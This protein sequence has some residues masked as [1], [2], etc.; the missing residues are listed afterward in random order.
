MECFQNDPNINGIVIV[1]LKGYE[2]YVQALAEQFKITKFLGVTLGGSCGQESI[3]NGLTLLSHF[4]KP[5]DIVL[6]HDG[7]RPLVSS[8]VIDDCIATTEKQGNACAAT[9]CNEAMLE[10]LDGLT[11][12]HSI[13][14]ETIKKTQ[15]PHGCRYGA[16]ME[17][18]AAAQK[19]GITNSVATVTL[20]IEMGHTI[21]FSL[22]SEKNFKIT[23]PNDLDIFKSLLLSD[24]AFKTLHQ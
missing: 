16:L 12:N 22:G 5:N 13:P 3:F 1:A 7:N 14:R 23:T 21:Y 8:D 6:I 24:P 2:A 11:S 10:S 20:L 9:P 17:L 4:A 19:R 15:T 18:H